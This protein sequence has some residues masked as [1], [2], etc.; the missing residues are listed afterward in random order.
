V[1]E[2]FADEVALRA[3]RE[4]YASATVVRVRQ[5]TSSHPGDRAIVT[6]SGQVRGWVGGSCTQ[7]VVVREALAVIAAGEPRLLEV[8][9]EC[10]SE[11][12]VEV[13][14]EPHLPTPHVLAVGSAPVLTLLRDLASAL[15]WGVEIVDDPA[16]PLGGQ[17]VDQDTYV[18]VATFGRYDE[19]AVAA[20]LATPAAYVGLVASAKRAD[21]VRSALL[22]GGL[23]EV[24]LSRLRAPA[25]LDLGSLQHREIAVALLGEMVAL[26]AARRG[27]LPAEDVDVAGQVDPVCGMSVD[28]ATAAASTE[29]D[30]SRYWFCSGGCRRRFE[31]DPAAFLPA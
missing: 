18:V 22:A 9:M 1:S 31:A 16:S 20:A 19:D 2:L 17:A 4:P 23:A 15:G 10:A 25:G 12:E 13:F 30:G 21:A 11:G 29:H 3:A 6:A 5:P 27:R 26:A 14:I 8:P 24:A 28:P 7:P